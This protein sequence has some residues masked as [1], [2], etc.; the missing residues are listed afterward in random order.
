MDNSHSTT[1]NMIPLGSRE[2]SLLAE[3]QFG[4][5][6]RKKLQLTFAYV[7]L[8]RPKISIFINPNGGHISR[9]K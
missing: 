9:D 5:E 2:V 7:C 3:N 4:V 6:E 1:D 8:C